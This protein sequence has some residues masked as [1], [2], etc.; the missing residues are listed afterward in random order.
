[1]DRMEQLQDRIRA[2]PNQLEEAMNIVGYSW[3]APST[4]LRFGHTEKARAALAKLG[5]SW[6]T[7]DSE[8]D[9]LFRGTE[10]MFRPRG[11]K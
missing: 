9:E 5:V 4:W 8:Y 11:D 6:C 7:T 10:N 2:E 1:M 3:A